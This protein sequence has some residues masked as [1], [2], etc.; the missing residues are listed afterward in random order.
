M[1]AAVPA[2]FSKLP[3]GHTDDLR[4]GD[5]IYIEFPFGSGGYILFGGSEMFT[6]S[7]AEPGKGVWFVG[8]DG[9]QPSQ[10]PMPINGTYDQLV[11]ALKS[12]TSV[13]L[14]EVYRPQKPDDFFGSDKL[15]GFTQVPWTASIM[16]GMR[17][18]RRMADGWWVVDI[19]QVL[20]EAGSTGSYELKGVVVSVP[21]SMASGGKR[22]PGDA[23]SY[24]TAD[25]AKAGT[26]WSLWAPSSIAQ[27]SYGGF[28]W[29]TAALVVGGLAVVGYVVYYYFLKDRD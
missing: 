23:Y 21:P 20:P 14:V 18:S 9:K 16:P 10:I 3:A 26:G 1:L 5:K 7:K 28:S 11:N 19:Q 24:S 29:M 15:A 25:I 22:K 8:E 6:V 4:E 12:K 13:N 17:V 27:A 2:G